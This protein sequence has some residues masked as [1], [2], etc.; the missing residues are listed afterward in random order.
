MVVPK[1]QPCTFK[2]MPTPLDNTDPK[3]GTTTPSSSTVFIS[4][5]DDLKRELPGICQRLFKTLG[6]QQSESTYQRCL[7][8]DLLDAGV[9]KVHLEVE[10]PLTYKG[11]V[12]SYRRADMIVEL[13]CGGRA[14]LEFKAVVKMTV[15][16]RKQLEYYM[17]HA[18]IEEGYLINF[19]HD[20]G[21]SNV[22]DGTYFDYDGLLGRFQDLVVGGPNL[23]PKNAKREVDIV[24][25]KRTKNGI[26]TRK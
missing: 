24:H 23:R 22:D 3:D 6:S 2:M 8:M 1:P 13:P 17:H 12:V 14:L 11:V 5:H 20:K 18:G 9:E 19:P 25:I 15:D 10:L 21:Y 16:H 4:N 7:S 26:K